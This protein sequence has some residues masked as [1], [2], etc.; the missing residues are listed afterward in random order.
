MEETTF[1]K[2]LEL[3]SY[4]NTNMLHKILERMDLQLFEESDSHT[5]TLSGTNFVLDFSNLDINLYFIEEEYNNKYQYVI[6]Y[7]KS[8]LENKNYKLFYLFLKYFCAYDKDNKNKD[9][10]NGGKGKGKDNKDK[11]NTITIIKKKIKV[12]NNLYY[13]KCIE[14]GNYCKVLTYNECYKINNYNIFIHGEDRNIENIKYI[15]FIG[16]LDIDYNYN[17]NYIIFYLDNNK[18]YG[19]DK[20]YDNNS[21]KDG[22]TVINNS[23]I[24]KL[25][26]KIDNN[27]N[28]YFNNKYMLDISFAVKKGMSWNDILESKDIFFRNYK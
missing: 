28:V 21:N 27:L 13:C 24:N 23:N 8:T 7:L 12:I 16:N 20:L 25:E 5:Y 10:S 11:N 6:Q 3:S 18:L 2:F 26:V 4:T 19:N 1:I 15:E 14:E 17:D 9:N 22:D